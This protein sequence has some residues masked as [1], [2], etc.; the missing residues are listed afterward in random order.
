MKAADIEKTK[1]F[2]AE[3]KKRWKAIFSFG[4]QTALRTGIS[5][6]DVIEEV[7]NVRKEK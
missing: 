6:E 1:K 7:K 4:E 2:L 3:R 5:E